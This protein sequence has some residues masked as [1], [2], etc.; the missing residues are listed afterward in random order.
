MSKFFVK[1]DLF[2][3]VTYEFYCVPHLIAFWMRLQ[4]SLRNVLW[5]P[6]LIKTPEYKIRKHHIEF[7][8]T[9]IFNEIRVCW[10]AGVLK[11]ILRVQ[12]LSKHEIDFVYP[13]FL[14]MIKHTTL[15]QHDNQNCPILS[16]ESRIEPVLNQENE[17]S[18]PGI[19]KGTADHGHNDICFPA[20]FES[21]FGNLNEPKLKGFDQNLMHK[22]EKMSFPE[23]TQTL[24]N[25]LVSAT[26][27]DCSVMIAFRKSEPNEKGLKWIELNGLKFSYHLGIVDLDRKSVWKIPEHYELEQQLSKLV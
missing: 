4:A 16:E 20:R 19:E 13:L 7:Y 3:T 2:K 26:A 9:L 5:D 21:I 27:K 24:R 10:L 17:A 12:R 15:D 8:K 11:S 6:H 18:N 25:Y 22:I 14:H 23:K 1:L